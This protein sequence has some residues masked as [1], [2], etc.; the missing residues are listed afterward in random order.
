[1]KS[2]KRLLSSGVFIAKF[3]V[4]QL[5]L[6]VLFFVP[7]P[8]NAIDAQSILDK[9]VTLNVQNETLQN[10]VSLIKKQT[11]INISFSAKTIKSNGS[12]T[13][14][15]SNKKLV[16]VLGQ[17]FAALDIDYR[18]VN[19]QIVLFQKSKPITSLPNNNALL[20]GTTTIKVAADIV[21]TGI[22]TNEKK[23]PIGGVSVNEKGTKNSVI[24]KDDGSFKINVKNSSAIL[25]TNYIG[26]SSSEVAV[27][28]QLVLN[29][30][31]LSATN[32]LD[33]VIVVGYGT[34]KKVTT[35]GAVASIGTKE[36]VQSPV[37]NI[38]NSLVGRLPGLFATQGG[39]EPGNDA[40]RI[41]IRGI[42]TFSGNT[43]PLTLVDGVQVD[44]FNNIDP[45]E[46]ESVTILKDA[47]STA[48]YGI[49]GANGVLLV[50]TKRGKTGPPR[51]SYTFNQA[52]NSFTD[53][54]TMMNSGD[55]ADNF[56]RAIRNDA[57]VTGSVYVPRYSETDIQKYRDGSDPIFF[58]NKDWAA[59]LFRNNAPQSQQNI[60]VSGGQKKVKYFVSAGY[61]RQEG[62]FVDTKNIVDDYSAQSVF[63]RYN[64]RSN[65]NFELTD[66]FK[67]A[68]DIAV[69][70][71]TRGG[72]NGTSTERVVGDIFRASPLSTPG[73]VDGKLVQIFTGA[74]NN[75]YI[76]L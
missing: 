2:K 36:L 50:T 26:Y 43:D 13:L 22:I 52:L 15:V 25:V 32:S 66:K 59:E 48:I 33:D 54:R 28:D 12:I 24:T 9:K 31:L 29:I 76:T 42:G 63:N 39:G 19:D 7:L 47:A 34:Q 14:S 40:S 71:E 1:M 37:A 75:P 55:Y 4:S 21:I 53:L 64:L 6:F 68:L 27:K 17:E 38:S 18:L 8:V 57:Y 23:E 70:T 41:R 44:N 51:I 10:V 49:R 30:S 62:Q 58:P 61:F 69:Q 74:Q 56:N 35:T 60:S 73:V 45:N 5:C 65:F 11:D 20:I 46:I 3:T 72:N 16:D 67:M